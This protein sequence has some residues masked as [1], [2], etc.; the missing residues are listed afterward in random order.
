MQTLPSKTYFPNLNGLRFFAALFVIINHI[1]DTKR[2]AGYDNYK[3]I[4]FFSATGDLSVTL[5]FVLSGFLITYL[6]LEE[7]Q[8]T[9]DI[10]VKKFYSKRI[11]RI[12]PLYL[13]ILLITFIILYYASSFSLPIPEGSYSEKLGFIGIMLLIIVPNIVSTIYFLPYLGHI[14]SIGVEEQFYLIWPWVVKFTKNYLKIFIFILLFFLII[15]TIPY[16]VKMM[17]E[18]PTLLHTTKT[19]KS[20]LSRIRINC[21]AIGGFGAWL[22]FNKK[23][24]ILQL[25]YRKEVQWVILLSIILLFLTGPTI[26]LI[27]HEFYS[28]LFCILI[29]N[30]ASNPRSI[31]QLENKPLIFL[32]KISYGIYMYHPLVIGLC[33]GALEQINGYHFNTL[34]SDFIVYSLSISITIMVSTLSYYFFERFFLQRKKYFILNSI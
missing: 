16:V 1:E 19:L 25:L 31:L 24:K 20:C 27:K 9:G 11:K 28:I 12:W 33:I 30:L 4:P 29:I 26:R 14:W 3:H 18:D 34:L 22:I 6:L 15:D 23:E 7:K 2:Y 17:T 8:N 13:F 10:S 5:F 32:G 21:M